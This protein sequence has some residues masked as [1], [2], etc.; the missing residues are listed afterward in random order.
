[1]D[2]AAT[3]T[4]RRESIMRIGAARGVVID[5]DKAAEMLEA[6]WNEHLDAWRRGENYGAP[7]AARWLLKQM[8]LE[9]PGETEAKALIDELTLAIEDATSEVGT[10]VVEGAPEALEAVRNAG[11]PTALICDT[12]FTPGRH[13]R[14]F[15]DQHGCKL[16]HYFF[17]DEFGSPKPFLPIFEAALKATGAQPEY[18]VHI[19]DL[20]RTDIQG[21]RNAGMATVRFIGV[22]DDEWGDKESAGED[23]D[24]ILHRW[25][26]LPDLLGL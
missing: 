10:K 3:M 22:H 26:D 25:S 2:W 11:I 20:R 24:A 18:A 12:G 23:A 8:G 6:S 16:D 21:A 14:Q 1:M 17:S 7:G 15:L 9:P 19:G 4:K 13:T 5:Q